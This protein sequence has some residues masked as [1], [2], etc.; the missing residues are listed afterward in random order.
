MKKTLSALILISF[1]TILVLPIGNLAYAQPVAEC[2]I[3]HTITG[4]GG[5]TCPASEKACPYNSTSNDCGICCVMEKTYTI[6]DW[7]FIIFISL[8][9]IFVLWGGFLL[10]TAAGNDEKVANG[11]KWVTWAMIGLIVAFLAKAV[12]PLVR[13]IIS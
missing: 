9:V 3:K 10:M 4:I 7:I 2:T 5:I 8:A 11:R 6:T 13:A 12:P 1:L